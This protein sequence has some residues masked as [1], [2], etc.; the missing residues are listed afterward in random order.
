MAYIVGLPSALTGTSIVAAA[1]AAISVPLHG[2]FTLCTKTSQYLFRALFQPTD[3]RRDIGGLGARKIH[4]RHFRMWVKQEPD[5]AGFTEFRPLG[6]LLK[7]RRIS[8]GLA[9]S[10][11]NDM[12]RR[13]PKLDEPLAI[14]GVGRS[15]EV[16][17]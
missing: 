4:V 10:S 3:I 7:W 2:Q 17:G 6:N 11:G 1:T 16:H 14:D 8:I 5:R 13:A 9:L 15:S 12:T